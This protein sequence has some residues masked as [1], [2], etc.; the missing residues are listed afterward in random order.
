MKTVFKIIFIIFFTLMLQ[1]AYAQEEHNTHEKMKIESKNMITIDPARLQSIGITYEPARIQE[2][3][4]IIRTV[5]HI[6]ADERRTAHI[7]VKFDGWIE[8]LFIDYTGQKVKK[9][10][11]LFSVYSPDLVSTQQEYL[12]ALQA[13]NILGKHAHSA[14]SEGA[15][16]ALQAAK[17]RLL[18]WGVSEKQI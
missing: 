4:K 14:A 8:K 9:G 1:S 15:V 17:Q 18:L 7:H 5:G 11:M 3:E 6:E 10:E 13:K 12:L 16:G 2:I